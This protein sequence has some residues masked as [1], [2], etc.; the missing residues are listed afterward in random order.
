M[1]LGC[2]FVGLVRE[3]RALILLCIQMLRH[4]C[5]LHAAFHA[6]RSFPF[7]SPHPVEF[8]P[9]I[10]LC[11]IFEVGGL[12][13]SLLIVIRRI[14]LIDL[15]YLFVRMSDS[16]FEKA[17]AFSFFWPLRFQSLN[18]EEEDDVLALRPRERLC[19][20]SPLSMRRSGSSNPPLIQ[21]SRG[22]CMNVTCKE[23]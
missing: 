12:W 3:T 10:P 21:C 4:P 7:H 11:L 13:I 16:C 20:L 1:M 5:R 23:L 18:Q 15:Q 22:D 8:V 6:I 2:A 17:C 14:Y 9:T 19:C